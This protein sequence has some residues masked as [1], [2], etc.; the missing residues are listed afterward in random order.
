MDPKWF[1]LIRWFGLIL[2]IWIH[3]PLSPLHYDIVEEPQAETVETSCHGTYTCVHT[4]GE[5]MLHW[6]GC[7][8]VEQDVTGDDD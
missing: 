4:A 5:A 8:C 2:P 3:R 6:N 1:V 7:C